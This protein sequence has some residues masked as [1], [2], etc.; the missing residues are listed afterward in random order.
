MIQRL[1]GRCSLMLLRLSIHT[2]RWAERLHPCRPTPTP[3]AT[4]ATPRAPSAEPTDT[5]APAPTPHMAAGRWHPLPGYMLELADTGFRIE[6]HLS[7]DYP[8][9]L[10]T[11]EGRRICWGSDLDGIKTLA[12]R[13][14]AFREAFSCQPS[15]YGW[16]SKR[17]A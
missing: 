10:Y 14:A 4:R 13:Q 1:K 3:A 15:T 11:P 9:H 12:E 6:L 5:A 7:D 8:Y 2:L 17:G 16:V